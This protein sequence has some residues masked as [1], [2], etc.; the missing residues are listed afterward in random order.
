[1]ASLG[2][3]TPR[4]S[5]EMVNDVGKTTGE[6]MVNRSSDSS[7]PPPIA[8]Q[9]GHSNG[10]HG[11]RSTHGNSE[12]ANSPMDAVVF[13]FRNYI[14]G[15]ENN[16]E[17]TE[18]ETEA[19]QSLDKCSDIQPEKET[20]AAEQ[21]QTPPHIQSEKADLFK[22][23]KT[24]AAFSQQNHDLRTACEES[25]TP[26][27]NKVARKKS[28][29][30]SQSNE[31]SIN[32]GT[33]GAKVDHSFMETTDCGTHLKDKDTLLE[34][35]AERGQHTE[36]TQSKT[37][38]QMRNKQPEQNKEAKKKK[39]RKK[40]KIGKGTGAELKAKAV[41]Q[42]ENDGQDVLLTDA[43]SH[44]ESPADVVSG[45]YDKRFDYKQQLNPEGKPYSNPQ[46][47][48]SHSEEDPFTTPACSPVS[49]QALTQAP[50]Q[51]DN[52]NHM[53][54]P[55]SMNHSS[56]E[57]P[58]REQ[59]VTGGE[60][61]KQS[62]PMTD[63][64]TAVICPASGNCSDAQT[65][66]A[67][68]TTEAK[69]LTQKNQSLLFHSQTCVGESCVESALEQA[70]VVVSALPLTTPTLPELIES[71]RG[72]ESIR[73][74]SLERVATVA[75]AESEKGVGEKKL[76]GIKKYPG[77]ADEERDE[78]LDNIPQL[79]I[80][81]SQR[82]C[83]L[84]FSAKEGQPEKSCSSE[85][86]HNSAETEI[87]GPGETTARSSDTEIFLADEG[88]TE[89]ETVR[90]EA[91]IN[92]SLL[93]LLSDQNCKDHSAVLSGGEGERE[94][95]RLAIEHSSFSQPVG[96]ASGV[97]SAESETCPPTDVA[98]SQLKS[99][100]RKEII[101]TI[102]ESICTEQDRLLRLCQEQGSAAVSPL[103]A[104]TEQSPRNTNGRI[105]AE[106]KLTS[107]EALPLGCTC[108]ESSIAEI[109]CIQVLPS[110]LTHQPSR[111]ISDKLQADNN[112]QVRP[113]ST[114]EERTP[115]SGTESQ[116]LS[117]S[118]SPAMSGVSVYACDSSRRSNR[119]HFAD[120]VK[121]SSSLE[122]KNMSV[123][124]SLPPLTV[125]ES[126]YHPVVE[127]SYTFPEFLH[128]DKPEIPTNPAPA[129]DEAAI[130]SSTDC[131]KPQK[132]VQL[133]NKNAGTENVLNIGIDH[134]GNLKT[135]TVDLSSAA[136][137]CSEQL[138][139]PT[140]DQPAG[141]IISEKEQ[142]RMETQKAAENMCSL[143]EKHS[144]DIDNESNVSAKEDQSQ[145]SHLI[146][147]NIV[148][149]EDE[150]NHNPLS[151]RCVHPADD[152]TCKPVCDV[153]TDEAVYPPCTS[154]PQTVQSDPSYPPTQLDETPLSGLDDT[155]L[156]KAS[157]CAE[158]ATDSADLTKDDSATP[159]VTASDQ[160]SSV[161]GRSVSNPVC[162]LSPPGPMLS[163]LEFI[164]D[165]DVSLP[166]LMDN[167]GAAAD[168]SPVSKEVDGYKS[169]E[170]TQDLEYSD[171]KTY[172]TDAC[173]L[174]SKNVDISFNHEEDLPLLTPPSTAVAK[175]ECAPDSMSTEPVICEASIRD[176]LINVSCPLISDLPPN[177]TRN[178]IEQANMKEML[179][180]GDQTSMP[181]EKDM[182][183][184]EEGTMA[185]NQKEA[186]D[187][188]KQQTG[189]TGTAPQSVAV[190]KETGALQPPDE[191]KVQKADTPREIKKEGERKSSFTINNE[192]E[193]SSLSLSRLS[194]S[195]GDTVCAEVESSSEIR[196]AYDKRQALTAAL[197]CS[198]DTVAAPD[199]STGQLQST[200]HPNRFAQ[201]QQQQQQQHQPGTRHP[202]E[203]LPGGCLEEEEKKAENS[204]NQAVVPGGK[205]AAENGFCQSESKDEVVCDNSSGRE[206]VK[207]SEK[208]EVLA[209]VDGFYAA[210]YLASDL[211][212]TVSS[213]ERSVSPDTGMVTAGSHVG[214]TR[215]ETDEKELGLGG[216]H[217]GLMPGS[218]CVSNLDG[219]G[220]QK[221][222]LLA[223]C[224]HQHE[225]SEPSENTDVS[226]ESASQQHETSQMS[227]SSKVS[228]DCPDMQADVPPIANQAEEI[229][230]SISSSEEKDFKDAKAV[231]STDTEE[232]ETQHTVCKPLQLQSSNKTSATQS[233]PVAQT[234]IKGPDV[235]EIAKEDK[236]A[237][238]EGKV[239]SQGTGQ[240]ET[241]DNV[242]AEKQGA[243]N[244]TGLIQSGV[245]Q[246]NTDTAVCL[247][248][249]SSGLSKQNNPN[250]A[251]PVAL[252][253]CLDDL[254]SHVA[255]DDI[256]VNT[257]IAASQCK[258]KTAEKSP[259][260]NT[261]SEQVTVKAEP[262]P[263][264]NWIKA[265]KEA[266]SQSQ[267][268]QENTVDTTR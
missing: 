81:C 94:E 139:C 44:R 35:E 80:I 204:L 55:S 98:E 38:K 97:S 86:P 26:D 7:S 30:N 203:E 191:H 111:Q 154:S 120:G 164:S 210:S 109:D 24:Q 140:D 21:K 13:S 32:T 178:K 255:Q 268:E 113:S 110:S 215:Q 237:S 53:D 79:S 183:Q 11:N 254:D 116:S 56:S 225:K 184:V 152:A 227:L 171:V 103:P 163:H 175:D 158:Y 54:T 27:C 115:R 267:S 188:S 31:C 250:T 12:A 234:A 107:E 65:E 106:L 119:V 141:S 62:A 258:E 63:V 5:P 137:T 216:S 245:S 88:D 221:G 16:I 167:C 257:I 50:H 235:K 41:V 105:S 261:T 40:K 15:T 67:T 198:S 260:C 239:S 92:T 265:L 8:A 96:S 185:N 46:L 43:N 151:S 14:L 217:A 220:Q 192:T 129:K 201:Q 202:T 212:E 264:T 42:L 18:T 117:I 29:K 59:H 161:I 10:G 135:N 142:C 169:K 219:K 248:E 131:Q 70:S 173:E 244:L 123:S 170:M 6:V 51:S 149:E 19:T 177:D 101:S 218:E 118:S 90:I 168:V 209:G 112:Q 146:S 82:K 153:S 138:P 187:S 134:T 253:K 1:M 20:K 172:E 155:D 34:A 126:L 132:D 114:T 205:G 214:E 230:T 4:P 121:G 122:L 95:G 66:K 99:Q 199:L 156:M 226:V 125:H 127:A 17:A 85:M 36:G 74:D 136:E 251:P 133:E 213:A 68:V 174:V 144:E 208:G 193:A 247:S 57:I 242:A 60:T 229:H 190:V 157:D 37:E 75:V 39:H 252:S 228:T 238:D 236:A 195:S 73:S 91:C 143:K 179:Q 84:A 150:K 207:G 47:S 49:S 3:L 61:N 259:V 69:I 231:K 128:L 145:I 147:D 197:E 9:L 176:D 186:A 48:P 206:G 189:K 263:E 224:Q 159:D 182:K 76:T 233:S 240:S 58:Q 223:A 72:G 232:C 93:G 241:E 22:K 2:I 130:W 71:K 28:K 243:V 52:H 256:V 196:T 102:P 45:I 100:S 166:E 194:G 246:N 104:P 77:T 124:A 33:P 23:P 108:E 148:E 266:A 25:N 83:S 162:V 249:T 180:T 165:C 200:S 78:D 222:N 160:S 211:N 89:K 87:K 64:Q 262:Q 181:F